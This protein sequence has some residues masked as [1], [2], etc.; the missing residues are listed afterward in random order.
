M[1]SS[2]LYIFALIGISLTLLLVGILIMFLKLLF[3]YDEL[4]HGK[5]KVSVDP[6]TLVTQARAR[7]QQILEE[8]HI[9]SRDMVAKAEAFLKREDGALNKEI[10]KAESVYLKTY[11]EAI[12]ASGDKAEKMIQNIPQD[13]K[14]VLV[15]VIDNFRVTLSKEIEKAQQDANKSIKEAYE[16]AAEEVNKY[17]EDRMKQV[18]SSILSIVKD[19]TEKVLSKSVSTEEHEKLVQ[20]ALEEA[21]RQKVF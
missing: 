20:K 17:K 7:S 14:L 11:N 8:A 15:S 12:K 19:V 2:I 21:K 6:E 10:E 9:K 3:K 18:D 13:I 5:E 16:K 4:K 1:D